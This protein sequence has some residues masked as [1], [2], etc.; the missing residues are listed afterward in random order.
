MEKFLLSNYSS[1]SL[2]LIGL[3]VSLAIVFSQRRQIYG[4]SFLVGTIMV[5]IVTF[6]FLIEIYNLKL[7]GV[8]APLDYLRI[9]P[10]GMVLGLVAAV[11]VSIAQNFFKFLFKNFSKTRLKLY[12]NCLA[13][14]LVY[15]LMIFLVTTLVLWLIVLAISIIA[16]I[17]ITEIIARRSRK[18]IRFNGQKWLVN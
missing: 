1:F 6:V 16:T 4:T 2:L 12:E 14:S 10:I 13:I 5:L 8:V 7:S 17:I 15:S 9:S 11:L 3:I 18:R